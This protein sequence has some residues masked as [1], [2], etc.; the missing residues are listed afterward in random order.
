MSSNPPK[1]EVKNHGFGQIDFIIEVLRKMKVDKILD[2]ALTKEGHAP[3][4]PY[5]VTGMLFI[6]NIIC[7]QEPLYN[8]NEIFDDEYV[9]DFK[10]SFGIDI[11]LDQ[12][13]DDRF[14]LF[15]DR[16]F[17]AGCKE[18]FTKIMVEAMTTFSIK[19][20]HVNYDTTS[21]TMWGAYHT[22]EGS[23]VS[24]LEVEY[25]YNKQKRH[26]KKQLVL[27]LGMSGG[28]AVSAEVLSG[29]MN[30][31]TF[32]TDN[33][34]RFKELNGILTTHDEAELYYI[35]DSA[36]A[37]SKTFKKAEE[38]DVKLI[39]RLPDNCLLTKSM[40]TKW[41]PRW[42]EGN[43]ISI[44]KINKAEESHYRIFEDAGNHDG[45]ALKTTLCF[46][47]NLVNQKYHTLEKKR[48]REKEQLTELMKKSERTSTFACE[49]DA[50][51][52]IKETKKV[53]GKKLG[54]HELN[55]EILEVKQKA[56]GRQ[57]KDE[58]KQKYKTK[59]DVKLSFKEME[60]LMDIL[61]Q[62]TI[63]E[64]LFMLVSNDLNL[65]G[66]EILRQYK[67]QSSVEVKFQQFKSKHFANS[68]FVKKIERVESLM[69]MYLIGLQACTIIEH[70]IRRGLES[71]NDFIVGRGK[72]KQYRP[73][74]R[75]IITRFRKIG[76][77][78][79]NFDGQEIRQLSPN[80]NDDLLKML[81]YLDIDL[82]NFKGRYI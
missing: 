61:M 29:N 58:S 9:Y 70:V 40:V 42:H 4:I 52:W 14:G 63:K 68:L 31:K 60:N 75:T 48:D 24:E 11:T 51:K 17:E 59:Y 12:L 46:S 7:A 62:L 28:V 57:P 74:F 38:L 55:F 18:I 79:I 41:L 65:T 8:M 6:A 54:Y 23:K 53:Q 10:G 34:E 20:S 67:T 5:G 56:P 44:P 80:I 30:D 49:E 13:N 33:I 45:T 2:K 82:E 39:T 64:S 66:E 3:E 27:A 73:T 32:N 76:R 71:E 35:A 21:K 25:G 26:D 36:A 78:I 72:T 1:I 19:L 69:F 81:R 16:V 50:L 47:M 22:P 15:L 77:Q 43:D 37:T